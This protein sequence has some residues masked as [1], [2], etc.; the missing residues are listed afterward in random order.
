MFTILFVVF[1]IEGQIEANLDIID[2]VEAEGVDIHGA[3]LGK[4]KVG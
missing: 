1:G 3:I 4:G 2:D